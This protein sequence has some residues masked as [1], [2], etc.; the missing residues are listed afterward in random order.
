MNLITFFFLKLLIKNLRRQ[1]ENCHFLENNNI[2]II[3]KLYVN[4]ILCNKTL[5]EN[6][7]IKYFN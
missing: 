4:C 1:L 2:E 7:I 6:I 3:S 5:K